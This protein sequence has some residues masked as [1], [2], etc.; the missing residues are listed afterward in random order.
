MFGEG[1]LCSQI[2]KDELIE[3]TIGLA[4][5]MGEGDTIQCLL[6][7]NGAEGFANRFEEFKVALV[8]S[9]VIQASK[10]ETSRRDPSYERSNHGHKKNTTSCCGN[11]ITG[12][13]SRI[14]QENFKTKISAPTLNLT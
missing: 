9:N 7:G 1:V 10:I 8:L 2:N 3:V 14:R 6:M 4:E 5:P 13:H 12:G 11:T